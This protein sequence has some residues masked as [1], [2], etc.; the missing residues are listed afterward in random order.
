M[1]FYGDEEEEEDWGK[2]GQRQKRKVPHCRENFS[3]CT[4]CKGFSGQ[5]TESGVGGSARALTPTPTRD[6]QNPASQ[7]MT[8]FVNSISDSSRPGDYCISHATEMSSTPRE[9]SFRFWWQSRFVTR[10]LPKHRPE[11]PLAC[12]YLQLALGTVPRPRVKREG[13]G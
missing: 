5:G 3:G 6:D 13:A 9:T 10:H 4:L 12:V 7:L 2:D 8:D 11:G 1:Y